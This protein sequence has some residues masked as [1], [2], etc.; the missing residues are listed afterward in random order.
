MPKMASTG[1]KLQKSIAT[2][3]TTIAYVRSISGPNPETQFYDGTDLES[4]HLEDGEPTGQ[5]APGMVSGET[6][7]DPQDPTHKSVL[8]EITS[9][10]TNGKQPYKVVYPDASEVPFTATCRT[11]NPK[12]SV[13]E[14][15]LAD[16]ELK[17]ASMA[18]FPA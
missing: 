5:S 11:W 3:F 14:A 1:T 7:Y 8:G 17:L 16:F 4:D 9:P 18:T 12:A 13:G 15:L 10:R 6:F 2:I